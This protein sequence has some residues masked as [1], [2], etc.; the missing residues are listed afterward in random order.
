MEH[1]WEFR[2]LLLQGIGWTV[3]VSICSLII[4]VIFGLFGAWGKLGKHPLANKVTN[5]YTT[6]VRGIPDLVLMLLLFYGGQQLLNDI[7]KQTGLWKYVEINQ[8][9]AAVMTIGFI[10][11]A[12]MTETFRGAI[13]A[14][15]HGQIEAGIACGMSKGQIF[16]RIIWP[17]MVRYALPSFTNNWLVLMKTTALASVLGLQ[18]LTYVARSVGAKYREQFTF[19]FFA[20]IV[21][22]IFTAISEYGLRRLDKKYNVGVRRA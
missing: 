13:L 6:I 2:V 7:G 9:A 20:L 4:S 8:F 17:Q 3:L 15:P 12:Y 18:E 14:I 10:F 22:L 16:R 1:I 5:G 19:L 11:G 21:Y